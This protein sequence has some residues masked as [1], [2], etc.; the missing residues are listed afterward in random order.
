MAHEQGPLPV[1]SFT[2]PSIIGAVAGGIAT[3]PM[4]IFMLAAHRFLPAWQ[5]DALPP[6]KIT[7]EVADRTNM[8]LNK[9]ELLGATLTAHLGYGA[10]MGS[11]Y[12]TFAGKLKLPP[13]LKGSLFGLGV[14]A[15]SYMGWLPAGKFLAAG[16]NE[17]SERNSLMIIAHLIWGGVTGVVADLLAKQLDA[18]K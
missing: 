14:W 7:G 12:S 2:F 11:L 4:T 9:P 8:D 15:A 6:E 13:L 18:N 17:T 16:T 10:S 3:I 5:K 1:P